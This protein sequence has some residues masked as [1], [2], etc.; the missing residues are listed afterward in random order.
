[1]KKVLITGALDNIAIDI[2]EQEK[3]FSIT[4]APDLPYAEIYDIIDDYDC[5]IS[6]S[7]T[8]VDKKLIQKAKKLSVI[9]RAA[10]GIGNIDVEYATQRGILVFNTPGKNTNSAA[11]L[12]L[13]L[14]LSTLRKLPNAHS[15]M[16][17]NHWDR[18]LFTGTELLNKTVG[19]IGLGNVGHR[20]ARFLKGFDCRVLVY[21]PYISRV[22]CEECG[23]EQVGFKTLISESQVISIHVPKN[24][25]TVNM[26][27]YAEI[28]QMRNGVFIINTARG[29]IINEKAIE[30]GLKSKKIQGVGIDTWEVEPLENHPLKNYDNVVM[31]P[32]IGASTREA[33]KRIAISIASDT[34]RALSGQIPISPVNLPEMS[35]FKAPKAPMYSALADKLGTF[36]KQYISTEFYPTKVRFLYRGNLDSSDWSMIKL[37]FLKSFLDDTVSEPVSFVNVLTIAEEKGISI[38][39][40]EEKEFSDYESA[41]RIQVQG[42]GKTLCI[43]GTV[44]G[45]TNLRLSYL[46]GFIFEIAPTG[47]VIVIENQDF[48]GVIGHVGTVLGVHQINI[49]QFELS[50]N[51][52]GGKAMALVVIDGDISEMILEEL[53]N[54]PYM[55]SLK[56]VKF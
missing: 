8:A 33:Q 44:C 37:S 53:K 21:D 25:E 56:K 55:L 3:E 42:K 18:H 54:Q 9:A 19:L 47:T 28:D 14:I 45:K 34:I 26:I 6:R 22:R 52:K 36:S 4:Y 43:G 40:C 17:G 10:V 1:M 27:D 11:E 13:T 30:A 51:Q 38:E 5:L 31:T 23:A 49:K 41:I 35:S 48:P 16:Q 20:V 50:R 32:H 15:S 12:A 39:E 2:L 7:E 24:Q 29:G 46:N